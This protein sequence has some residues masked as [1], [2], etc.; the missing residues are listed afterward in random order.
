[1]RSDTAEPLSL[2]FSEAMKKNSLEMLQD[3]FHFTKADAITVYAWALAALLPKG[4]YPILI[5]SA[6]HGAGKSL[7]SELLTRIIDPN[8]V[9]LL[10]LFKDETSLFATAGTRHVIAFDNLS[11][12][13]DEQSD[14]LCRLA[15]GGGIS[16]R[17][18]YTDSEAIAFKAE[19]PMLFNGISPNIN[20]PDLLDRCYLVTLKPISEAERRTRADLFK[21]FESIRPYLL[22]DLLT[23]FV[24]ALQQKD[25][26]PPQLAR[27][28]DAAAIVLRAE[29]A[30]AV[31]WES[32]A[33]TEILASKEDLKKSE[34][35]ESNPI[36]LLILRLLD[37]S[38]ECQS[39]QNRKR[40][41][42]TKHGG[43]MEDLRNFSRAY[44]SA[45]E[46][47]QQLLCWI[48]S[49]SEL[50]EWMQ[51]N[52]VGSEKFRIPPAA[53][54]GKHLTRLK[55]LLNHVGIIA[56][57]V[58]DRQGNIW[59]LYKPTPDIGELQK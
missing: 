12:I 34:A 13:S 28:A 11:K 19:R 55:S 47:G 58:R 1:L 57:H 23:S 7:T 9:P 53:S 50:A 40:D 43:N 37:D 2:S 21:E 26:N 14:I 5:L 45:I 8:S 46:N 3:F 42:I 35:A 30:E 24:G 51:K 52:S 32:G 56:L 22:Y 27:M 29:Q 48:G 59:V 31:P 15:T 16:N 38:E 41:W 36:V 44:A 17:K 39:A 25:Y 33:F 20:R 6:E 18:Y 54:L 10:G 49:M 4:P